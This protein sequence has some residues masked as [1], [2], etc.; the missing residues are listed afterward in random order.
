MLRAA[1]DDEHAER[2]K[3][4]NMRRARAD[5]QLL[6]SPPASR[7]AKSIDRIVGACEDEQRWRASGEGAI[8]AEMEQRIRVRL[9]RSA[10]ERRAAWLVTRDR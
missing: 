8:R 1:T 6:A 2:R 3:P 7:H 4:W 9:E 5:E 10:A